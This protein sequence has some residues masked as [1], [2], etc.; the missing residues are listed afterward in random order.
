MEAT[1]EEGDQHQTPNK[2]KS[3]THVVKE[4][5][6]ICEDELKPR[7]GLQFPNLEECEKFYKSYAHFVG[8]SIRKSRS[9]NNNEGVP[10]YKYY[11]CS[12]Q[13]FRQSSTNVKCSRK[14][15]LTREGCNAMVGFRRTSN[16]TYVLFKFH[17]GHTH[18]FATPR[19]RHMLNSNRGVTSV[20][21]TL[22]KS[23][24]CANIGPSK[25]HRIIKGDTNVFLYLLICFCPV[26]VMDH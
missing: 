25:A 17:E 4:W 7:E 21:R 24:A 6:P 12:K 3:P 18:E 1:E 23:L 5:I 20:H 15:K 16:E 26:L 10:K 11:V 2:C 22:F 13:G 9:K 19:K 14:V 8:F